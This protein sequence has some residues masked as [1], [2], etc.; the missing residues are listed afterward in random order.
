MKSPLTRIALSNIPALLIRALINVVSLKNCKLCKELLHVC[1]SYFQLPE[2][3]EE[4]QMFADANTLNWDNTLSQSNSTSIL[5]EGHLSEYGPNYLFRTALAAKAIESVHGKAN[6]TVVV[7]G[8]SYQ[9]SVARHVYASFGITRWIFL[10]RMLILI[11]P[12][13]HIFAKLYAYMAIRSLK[14]VSSILNLRFDRIRVGDLVYDEILRSIHAPT[15]SSIDDNVGKVIKRSFY[16]FLQYKILFTLKR[17]SFYISTHTTYPEYGLLCRL[18]LSK[19]IPVIETTDIQMSIFNGLS[20]SN[21]PTYHGGIKTRILAK[22]S[23]LN[24]STNSRVSRARIDLNRRLSAQV[25]QI[26]VLNAYSGKAYTREAL[27]EMYGFDEN[28]KIGFIMAHIFK[29][30]PHISPSMLY[31][32]YYV[33]LCDTIKACQ[34]SVNTFWFLKPHPSTSLYGEEGAVEALLE[35][36]HIT[37]TRLC[38][39]DLNTVSLATC[40]DVITTVHGTAGLEYSCLGIPV[41]LAGKPF[42]SELGFTID[43]PNVEAY[44][45]TLKMAANIRPLTPSQIDK[46][47]LVYEIWNSLFDW[48]NPIIT[49]DVLKS[50]WGNGVSRDLR[51]AYHLMTHNL[52]TSSPRDL[53][54]WQFVRSVSE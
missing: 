52:S 39:S 30:S 47:L 27:R 13:L 8:F 31:Q 19:G 38:P 41:I 43:P 21:L 26:D 9:W 18:A 24:G 5:V 17:F 25:D 49:S 54:L 48:E 32:D 53:K 11:N 42:Y 3:F 50:V 35:P 37:N 10:D 45:N 28:L 29:D 22:L 15:I 1:N 44:K 36:A 40:A 12:L 2:H 33:W 34:H 46:A 14:S 4:A 20:D 16:F 7:N 23:A 51:K 6:I